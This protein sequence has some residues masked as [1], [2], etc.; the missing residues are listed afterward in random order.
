L[1]SSEQYRPHPPR[2][3]QFL[4][5]TCHILSSP[6]P[7]PVVLSRSSNMKAPGLSFG[8]E[9]SWFLQANSG[10]V[11]YSLDVRGSPC[12]GFL[13]LVITHFNSF[14]RQLRRWPLSFPHRPAIA[15]ITLSS[16]KLRLSLSAVD[17]FC[18]SWHGACTSVSPCRI[19]YASQNCMYVVRNTC[20][21]F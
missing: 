9:I 10:I 19:S 13:P 12:S 2:L 20:S 3:A 5:A 18:A 7:T 14:H 6:S 15:H 1:E 8:R 21:R 17:C 4:T 16:V 11:Q